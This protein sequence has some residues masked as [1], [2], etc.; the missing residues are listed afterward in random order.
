MDEALID[1]FIDYLMATKTA[2]Q[3]T[4]KAYSEDLSQFL[5]YLKQKKLSEP[6]LVNAT[7][8][9]IRGFLAY[10]QEKKISKRTAARK[11]SALR[12]FYKY[13]VVEGFAQENIAK[14]ISTPKI[15]KKLPLFLYPGEIEVLLSAPKNDVLGIRDKAIME[16]LYATGM[17][18]GE[19]VSLKTS[20]INFGSN[21]IIVFGKGS[22]E[23]VVFF[24]QKA[25][26]S[27]EKYLKESRPF[28]TKDINCD[29]LFLNKNG[30]AI[31]ARSIRRIIDKYVKIATLNSEVSPH[32]LRHT[33]ATHML[34]NGADLKT[35]QELLGHSSLSTT[36]IYTH[37]TK[38]RLKEVYDKTF[39]HNKIN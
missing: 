31:S 3:N 24:G 18:V 13:L 27:L 37:V 39:P 32:T 22:K 21:Y 15:S 6:I 34:N 1:S 38:E 33:F 30:T 10:L 12:S 14:S 16:L 4:I 36:Q 20:D 9:H 17:R 8:L 23:R 11:L 25:E 29:S 19:L 7:H 35:V 28:L 5:E 2:S 26:E